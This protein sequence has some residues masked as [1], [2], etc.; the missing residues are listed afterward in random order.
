MAVWAFRIIPPSQWTLI[1]VS[2]IA[3]M[4]VFM[5]QRFKNRTFLSS[6]RK[7]ENYSNLMEGLKEALYITAVC[8]LILL[9]IAVS[10]S[11]A[12]EGIVHNS[13]RTHF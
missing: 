11:L 13:V 3:D 1:F 4:L 10:N 5:L 8:P 9:V 2:D 12:H 7:D 6:G